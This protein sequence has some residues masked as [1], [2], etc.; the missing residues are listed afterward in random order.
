MPVRP[1]SYKNSILWRKSEELISKTGSIDPFPEEIRQKLFLQFKEIVISV[2]KDIKQAYLQNDQQVILYYFSKTKSSCLILEE[3]LTMSETI[4]PAGF[5]LEY[6][7]V[8]DEMKSILD[9]YIHLSQINIV[10]ENKR[11]EKKS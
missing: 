6:L 1:I 3:M 11:K 10:I 2:Q 9:N 7:P 5:Y 4:F 8:I